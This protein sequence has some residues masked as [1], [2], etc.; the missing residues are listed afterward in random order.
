MDKLNKIF[1]FIVEWNI[2]TEE[3][4]KLVIN[5][6][7]WNENSLNDIIYVRSGYR[8]MESYKELEGVR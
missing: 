2:A 3:E 4:I 1:D 7:G 5:I 8:D 6:N